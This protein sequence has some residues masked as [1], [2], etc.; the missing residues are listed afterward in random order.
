MFTD[1]R[2]YVAMEAEHVSDVSKILTT[3][4]LVFESYIGQIADL[5]DTDVYDESV[6]DAFAKARDA[7]TKTVDGIIKKIKEF[8]DK[9]ISKF[10]SKKVKEQQ[11]RA[12]EALDEL[13]PNAKI[14]VTDY[15]S[16]NKYLQQSQAYLN[17]S[18]A[19]LGKELDRLNKRG[20]TEL[21]RSAV[22]RCIRTAEI[23]MSQYQTLIENAKNKKIQISVSE[24]KK[25][26]NEGVDTLANVYGKALTQS[27]NEF[28][29]KCRIVAQQSYLRT[30]TKS[31]MYESGENTDDVSPSEKMSIIKRALSAVDGMV[32]KHARGINILLDSIML[33][34]T[35]SAVLN[36]FGSESSSNIDKKALIRDTSIAAGALAARD[37]VNGRVQK[38]AIEKIAND[39]KLR[40]AYKQ[41]ID[42]ERKIREREKE[43]EESVMNTVYTE[44]VNIDLQKVCHMAKK[45]FNK[46]MRDMKRNIKVL[47]FKAAAENAK[48]AQKAIATTKAALKKY[49]AEDLSANLLGS[50][51][52][53][54]KVSVKALA[55]SLV[56]L[57]GNVKQVMDAFRLSDAAISTSWRGIKNR[58]DGKQDHR[59]YNVLYIDCVK[60]LESMERKLAKVS[61]KLKSMKGLDAV[62]KESVEEH[63]ISEQDE[64]YILS[65]VLESVDPEMLDLM[66]CEGILDTEDYIAEYKEAVG[67]DMDSIYDESF[68]ENEFDVDFS[69]YE[70]YADDDVDDDLF[71]EKYDDSDDFDLGDFDL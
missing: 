1:F 14:T 49:P 36:A 18:L 31:S 41:K 7:I 19:S 30:H 15:K 9:V 69:M 24:A 11:K 54:A 57:F 47:D 2:E 8:L 68:E 26:I 64:K 6:K 23:K 35:T 44:G 13:S 62:A 28:G 66:Y 25:I 39:K 3:G 45:T 63:M 10:T 22:D 17:K 37:V 34:G 12:S 51:V 56:P 32:V 48:E 4:E 38:V 42:S 52:G 27:V 65:Q 71:S 20:K 46:E 59:S 40:K 33:G 58:M 21:A 16:M 53:L 70:E 50:V 5:G 67:E 43:M 61:Q 60:W 55:W 29:R